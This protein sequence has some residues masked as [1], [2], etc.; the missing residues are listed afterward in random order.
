MQ[1]STERGQD[2][3][4]ETN[5]DL[6]NTRSTWLKRLI[7]TEFFSPKG[8]LLRAAG[9]AILFG[10]CHAAGLREHTTFLSG[11]EAE[12]GGGN[13]SAVWGVTYIAAYLGFVLLVPL[14]VLAAGLLALWQKRSHPK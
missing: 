8:F 1:T 6:P 14:L 11:T 9:L 2:A 10:I 5:R 3:F 12:A 7:W 13:A 4:S